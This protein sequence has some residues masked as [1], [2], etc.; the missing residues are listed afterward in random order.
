MLNDL[1]KAGG[2]AAPLM[3][4]TWLVG[5]GVFLGVLTPAG[6][7]DQR[8]DPADKV[9]ILADHQAI[10]SLPYLIAY[11]AFGVLLVFHWRFTTA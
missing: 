6:Y 10:A 2:V 7:F 11:V 5:F 9:A 4:A 3:A 8:I 1:Q